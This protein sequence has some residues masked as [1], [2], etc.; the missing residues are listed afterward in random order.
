MGYLFKVI[1]NGF[2]GAML[3]FIGF[4]SDNY[5]FFSMIAL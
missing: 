1:D 3:E 5:M 4:S 2:Y